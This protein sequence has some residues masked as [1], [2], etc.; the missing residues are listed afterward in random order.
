MSGNWRTICKVKET[1]KTGYNNGIWLADIK[2]YPVSSGYNWLRHKEQKVGWAKLVWS[3]WA[4]PKHQFVCWL[5][6]RNALNVK[7]RLYK[8][9]ISSNDLC[10]ICNNEHETIGH[11]FLSCSYTREVM[12][13][14][15]DWL[16]VPRPCGNGIIWVG[17][18][19]WTPMK[20]NIC[21][22]AIMAVYY[23]IWQQ[24]NQAR[25]EGHLQR[26]YVVVQQVQ[27]SVRQKLMKCN[28][29]CKPSDK[30]WIACL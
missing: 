29:I 28:E 18:R 27:S 7:E 19:N 21:L 24:R 14:V 5:L 15:C 11:L 3:K 10:C 9:G 2:G 13:G 6:L 4:V 8:H 16:C 1:L 17:R 20:K 26:P 22:S 30:I 25:L 23:L 12:Q